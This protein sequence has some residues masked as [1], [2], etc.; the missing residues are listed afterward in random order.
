MNDKPKTFAN[1]LIFKR[2][3]KAPDFVIGNLSVAEESFIPFLQEN[4]KKGWLNLVI[5]KSQKGA[6]YI[7]VDTFDPKLGAKNKNT[8]ESP[9]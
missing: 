5:K 6:Y 7:E 3:E 4:S 2:S 9:F 1:G 8:N